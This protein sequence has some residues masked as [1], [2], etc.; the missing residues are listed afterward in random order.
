MPLIDDRAS[1]RRYLA[2]FGFSPWRW[3]DEGEVITWIDGQ[4][5]AFAPSWSASSAGSP[6][7]LPPFSALVLL[8]AACRDN[9]RG[10]SSRLSGVVGLVAMLERREFPAWLGELFLRLDAVHALPAELRTTPAA[11]ADLA[12]V[13]FEEVSDSHFSSDISNRGPLD[14]LL[15]SESAH[16]DLTLAVRI[17]LNEALYLRRESLLGAR[18]STVRCSST[19]ASACGAFPASSPRPW[20]CRWWPPPIATF[21]SM[22]TGPAAG[23][24]S[25]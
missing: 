25:R 19:P 2:P 22:R 16:D 8:L 12:E 10:E 3:D 21:A 20:R 9:W 1:A 11:K 15:L 13:V 4:T 17:A 5:I 18:R 24:S 6:Y 23:R 7:G 14:R